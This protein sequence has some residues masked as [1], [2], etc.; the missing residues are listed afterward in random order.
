MVRLGLRITHACPVLVI[1]LSVCECSGAVVAFLLL[2]VGGYVW[3]RSYRSSSKLSDSMYESED[4]EGRQALIPTTA[5]IDVSELKLQRKIGCGGFGEVYLAEWRC[6]P[7][8]VKRLIAK[9]WWPSA[10]EAPQVTY[11]ILSFGVNLCLTVC[12]PQEA[13]ASLKR[14]AAI[15]CSLRHPNISL[16]MGITLDTR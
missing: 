3:Y 10:S 13:V 15:M 9:P 1:T 6:T 16:F 8:A 7:V 5:V 12:T 4:S 14:E 2:M 11:Y